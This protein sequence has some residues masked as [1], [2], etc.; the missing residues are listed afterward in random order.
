[1][2]T[3]R[4]SLARRR[5][6]ILLDAILDAAEKLIREGS[7]QEFTMR[8]LAE[9]AG[10]SVVT[11]YNHFG[12]KAGV[13]RGII[14]RLIEEIRRRYFAAPIAKGVIDRILAMAET[15]AQVSLEES[16]L[17][18]TVGRSLMVFDEQMTLEGVR[19][20]S[21]KLWR[22]AMGQSWSDFRND[23][24]VEAERTLPT[25]LAVIYR[26]AFSYW[27]AG[28]IDDEGFRKAV[29]SGVATVLLAFVRDGKRGDLIAFMHD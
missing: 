15:G 3:A 25:Q 13:M 27:I 5:N 17:Y 19:P 12:S 2:E 6:E 16:Q 14:R 24:A 7:S 29:R 11:A 28:E 8:A 10:V 21:E 18:R 20:E 4:D 23:V 9:E 26:G 22:D 1:M